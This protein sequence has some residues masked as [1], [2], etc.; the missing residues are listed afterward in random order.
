MIVY[1]GVT[2]AN[3]ERIKAMEI[4][5]VE[6]NAKTCKAMTDQLE[7]LGATVLT[8]KMDDFLVKKVQ[9]K[10]GKTLFKAIIHN[11]QSVFVSYPA[12]LF[13]KL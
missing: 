3:T 9:T 2:N 7:N 5:R 12:G 1:V 10:K 13:D 6:V 4:E 11:E 8:E